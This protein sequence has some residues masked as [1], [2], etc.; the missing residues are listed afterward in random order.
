MFFLVKTYKISAFLSTVYQYLAGKIQYSRALY[1]LWVAT[2]FTEAIL[3]I[4][5][6]I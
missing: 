2:K 3:A 1:K 4:V 5:K 6:S